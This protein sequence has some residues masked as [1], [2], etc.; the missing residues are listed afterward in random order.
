[1]LL[2]TS[3]RSIYNIENY[4]FNLV[5]FKLN[6][7]VCIR[8]VKHVFQWTSAMISDNN[9]NKFYIRIKRVENA[10]Y[11]YWR[12]RIMTNFQCWIQEITIILRSIDVEENSFYESTQT[13]FNLWWQCWII[14]T[15]TNI[16]EFQI[17]Q[18]LF[19]CLS[20]YLKYTFDLW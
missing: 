13:R 5:N 9:I 7:L 8:Y 15:K 4:L 12:I 18:C 16:K 10:I 19:P 17:T 2:L 6:H 1:M 14:S 3:S 20:K 11:R